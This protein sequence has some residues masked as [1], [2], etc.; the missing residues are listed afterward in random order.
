MRGDNFIR[1]AC[2][3]V[4]PFPL[5][6]F[7]EDLR[8]DWCERAWEEQQAHPVPCPRDGKKRWHP[9]DSYKRERGKPLITF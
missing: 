1:C 6:H 9:Q 3:P 7:W 8:C 2:H 4:G 5:H